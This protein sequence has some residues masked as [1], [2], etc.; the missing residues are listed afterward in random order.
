MG[1]IAD[2][3]VE[4]YEAG[5]DPNEMDGDDWADFYG[6]QEPVAPL[7][8]IEDVASNIR[9]LLCSI[10]DMQDSDAFDVRERSSTLTLY[11]PEFDETKSAAMIELLVTL[12]NA[13][14]AEAD[15]LSEPR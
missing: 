5:L 6:E 4:A 13:A 12:L 2:M 10:D 11:V 7:S 8:L 14:D 15:R 1:E 3:H 9:M